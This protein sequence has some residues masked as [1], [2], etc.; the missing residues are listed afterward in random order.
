MDKTIPSIYDMIVQC[1]AQKKAL[2]T[3]GKRTSGRWQAVEKSVVGYAM[4]ESRTKKS[5]LKP[6]AIVEEPRTRVETKPRNVVTASHLTKK[7]GPVVLPPPTKKEVLTQLVERMSSKAH[8]K[9]RTTS[10]ICPP[11]TN[12]TET[13]HQPSMAEA[14]QTERRIGS[15]K[16]TFKTRSEM[17]LTE[18][19]ASIT[20]KK[21]KRKTKSTTLGK[22]PKH[23]STSTLDKRLPM[24]PKKVNRNASH[25]AMKH[26]AL[27][28]AERDS[29]SPPA[30]KIVR[31][32]RILRK[33]KSKTSLQ[34]RGSEAK[35]G[36]LQQTKRSSGGD[37]SRW[38]M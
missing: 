9:T 21:K 32:K 22:D 36:S 35:A 27:L 30:E 3:E 2:Q 20:T 10:I 7:R 4:L 13:F 26:S 15:R 28:A 31:K 19:P 6:R 14:A 8:N 29:K 37:L 18:T 24:T 25:K 33:R 34:S 23:I 16:N 17:S 38:R 5:K 1:Q 11:E 12:L